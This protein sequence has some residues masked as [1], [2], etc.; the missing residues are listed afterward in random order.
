[1][2]NE[3]RDNAQL[4]ETVQSLLEE[5][6]TCIDQLGS[7]RS[8]NVGRE[9]ALPVTWNGTAPGVGLRMS[10]RLSQIPYSY[11]HS[12]NVPEVFPTG[13]LD[14]DLQQVDLRMKV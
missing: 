11:D 5:Y 1:M 7:G 4:P 3:T 8:E 10:A 9:K 12:L 6:H 2:E 13:K 14:A